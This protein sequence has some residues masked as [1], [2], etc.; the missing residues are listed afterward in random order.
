MGSSG[1][2]LEQFFLY[3]K[4]IEIPSSYL[5]E[6]SRWYPSHTTSKIC[7]FWKPP[8]F[9]S[10][11]WVKYIWSCRWPW[12]IL[13]GWWFTKGLWQNAPLNH[14]PRC[15]LGRCTSIQNPQDVNT[16]FEV[17]RPDDKTAVVIIPDIFAEASQGRSCF[18]SEKYCSRYSDPNRV[19]SWNSWNSLNQNEVSALWR[20]RVKYIQ[21]SDSGC[22]QKYRETDSNWWK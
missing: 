15:W 1:S 9:W 12:Q 17:Q 18:C 8:V 13:L 21:I 22:L 3:L 14:R 6:D 19:F 20:Q 10:T 16:A 5:L 7:R 2:D 4:S 11:L